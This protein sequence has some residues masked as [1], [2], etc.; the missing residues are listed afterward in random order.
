MC[1]LIELRFEGD[2]GV[3][4]PSCLAGAPYIC[5]GAAHHCQDL[6]LV[7]NIDPKPAGEKRMTPG[8]VVGTQIQLNDARRG[9]YLLLQPRL[10][11][12]PRCAA[13]I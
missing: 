1:A 9:N 6:A 3:A 12:W 5:D 10:R 4:A 2:P 7:F 8:A 11:N 13:P